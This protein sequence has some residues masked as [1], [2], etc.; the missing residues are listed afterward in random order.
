MYASVATRPDITF[1]LSRFL[2]NPGELH[3]DAVKRVFRYLAGTKY[4]ALTFCVERHD[5]IGYTDADGM[6][7]EDR[8]GILGY[9]FLTDAGTERAEGRT[10]LRRGRGRSECVGGGGGT[11]VLPPTYHLVEFAPA[12]A[13]CFVDS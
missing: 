6:A 5:L 9:N 10:C 4:L 13:G 8:R 1:M 12:G 2:E 7:Q 3:W 11:S